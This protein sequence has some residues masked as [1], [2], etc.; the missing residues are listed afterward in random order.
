MDLFMSPKYQ[1]LYFI[2]VWITVCQRYLHKKHNFKKPGGASL[3]LLNF[4]R[5]RVTDIFKPKK[6]IHAYCYPGREVYSSRNYI[7]LLFLFWW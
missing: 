6:M 2:S 5:Q 4:P 1:V 7:H 3:S